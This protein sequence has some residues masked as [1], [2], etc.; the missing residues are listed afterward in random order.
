[1]EGTHYESWRIERHQSRGEYRVIATPAEVSML[2]G[3]GNEVYVQKGAGEGSDSRM[4]HKVK[5]GAKL[6]DTKEEIYATCDFVAKVK[7]SLNRASTSC[8]VKTRSYFTCIH[9]AA[10]PEGGTGT[11]RQQVI[12]FTAEDSHRYG[13][14]NCEAAGK[15]GALFGLESLL[16]QRW[17]GQIRQRSRR[18][19]G[20]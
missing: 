10:H 5:E 15:A 2:V 20:R 4:R 6:V 9:P 17:Q 1:M 8:S 19:S 12:A 3:D 16:H 14:P 7:R 11:S 18:C 13:S